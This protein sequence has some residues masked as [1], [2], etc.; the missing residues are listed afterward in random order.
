MSKFHQFTHLSYVHF[1]VGKFYL[2]FKKKIVLAAVWPMDS[3]ESRKESGEGS[4][5]ALVVS[6]EQTS[7]MWMDTAAAGTET[8]TA[9]QSPQAQP[10]SWWQPSCVSSQSYTMYCWLGYVNSTSLLDTHSMPHT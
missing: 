5:Q 2:E 6:R 7:V 10:P 8:D 4:W 3:D 9:Y 1:T